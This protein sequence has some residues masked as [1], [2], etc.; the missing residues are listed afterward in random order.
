MGSNLYVVFFF[1]RSDTSQIP[2]PPP[3]SFLHSDPGHPGHPGHPGNGFLPA[4]AAHQ[5]HTAQTAMAA[6]R[7]V[8]FSPTKSGLESPLPPRQFYKA[9]NSSL[10]PLSGEVEKD[11]EK[12]S[13]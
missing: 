8:E 9:A 12:Y 4:A 3:S 1:F 13:G 10:N 5:T 2:P 11:Y 7:R 6:A